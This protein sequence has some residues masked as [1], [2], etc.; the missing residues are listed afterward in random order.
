MLNDRHMI[1]LV[2]YYN[3]KECFPTVEIAGG[4]CY[5]LW[6]S[7]TEND[8]EVINVTAG[9]RSSVVRPLNQFGSTFI[10]SNV[11]IS[12]INKVQEKCT[13]FM[14]EMVS[15]LDTFGIPSKEKGHSE[16][17][18]GDLILITSSGYNGQTTSYIERT[19]IKKNIDLIDKYK[20]KI[21]IMIPQSGE[22]GINPEAGYRSISTPQVLLPGQVDS[23]SYLNVGFLDTEEQANNLRDYLFCKFPRFMLRT[24]Y[25]SVHVS[26]ANFVFVPMVDFTK[27]WTDETLYQTFDLS[28][29][30][31]ELIEKTMRPMN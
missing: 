6:D 12:I 3:A 5:F 4:L 27:H 21:S 1:K 11:S 31:I 19:R 25:S 17:R 29:D 14:D 2:D 9:K 22:V 26:K 28:D 8:C 10:R 20:V 23:F 13:K 15:P 16:Y 18:E 24:T 30:E 7:V